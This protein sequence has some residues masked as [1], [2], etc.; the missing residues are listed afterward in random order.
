MGNK[1]I[2]ADRLRANIDALIAGTPSD[3]IGAPATIEA[4]KDVLNSIE[5][6]QQEQEP[7]C[8]TCSFYENDC[9][10][11]RGKFMPYPNKVCKDYTCSE[12]KA[13]E[14]P[15]L[16]GI[17]ESDIPGKDYIPVEW[18]DACEKYGKWKIVKQEQPEVD[19]DAIVNEAFDKYSSVDGYGQLSVSFNRA[20]LYSFIKKIARK[21]D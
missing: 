10:F 20:E 6:F 11:I 17:E 7:T 18:V 1:Y 14:Q 16:P 2:D 3:W 19:L 12:V 21:G 8:K 13:Q 5:L 15:D 9:P 4:Y